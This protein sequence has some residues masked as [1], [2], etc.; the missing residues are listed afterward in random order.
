LTLSVPSDATT[1]KYVSDVVAGTA[2]ATNSQGAV[3][4][5]QAATKLMFTVGPGNGGGLSWPWWSYLLIAGAMALIALIALQ[6]RYGVRLR[7]ERR[8]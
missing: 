4:G 7:V 8:R 3:A 1:G 5:A 6:R 2:A